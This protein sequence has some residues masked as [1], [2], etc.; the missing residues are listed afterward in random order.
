MN[1]RLQDAIREKALL[2]ETNS[3][4]QAQMQTKINS[5]VYAEDNQAQRV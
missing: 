5:T 3:Q 4:I 2:A 1:S